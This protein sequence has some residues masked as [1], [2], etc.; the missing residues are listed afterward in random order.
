MRLE[1]EGLSR[2]EAVVSQGARWYSN[3]TGIFKMFFGQLFF[4][5][6]GGG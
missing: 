2:C 3:P 6:G 4:R 1:Y 5:G